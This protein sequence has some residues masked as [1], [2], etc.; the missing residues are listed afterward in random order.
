M[1]RLLGVRHEV[2]DN[3]IA[4]DNVVP[5]TCL[6]W[7]SDSDKKMRYRFIHAVLLVL[8]LLL[9]AFPVLAE[10]GEETGGIFLVA[11]RDM[12]DP[13]FREAVVLVRPTPDGAIG[14]IVNRPTDI[15]LGKLFPDNP[16]LKVS[17]D[18]VYVGGP[19]YPLSLVFMFR[20]DEQPR[21]TLRMVGDVYLSFSLGLL[22]ELLAS[23]QPPRH[24]KVYAGHS[25]WGPGQ[26]QNEI[27]RGGWYVVPADAGV[28]FEMEPEKIWPELIKRAT[29]RRVHAIAK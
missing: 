16:V 7:N 29:T 10:T 28:I 11:K 4:R 13:N 3:T 24:L 17:N 5:G 1:R 9:W 6:R 18:N 12:L 22:E 15:P 8:A 23:P 20:S 27:E 25:G 2:D 19:V 26:L 14:V 21:Q